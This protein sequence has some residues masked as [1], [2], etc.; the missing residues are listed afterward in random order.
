MD[1]FSDPRVDEDNDNE[2]YNQGKQVCALPD[3]RFLTPSPVF[4]N[5]FGLTF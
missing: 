3:F 2:D 4:H 1:L 5:L